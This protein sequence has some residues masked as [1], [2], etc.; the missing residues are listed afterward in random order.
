MQYISPLV[1]T[2]TARSN[3]CH[4]AIFGRR[5]AG[6][7]SLLNALAGQGVAIV[8]DV[9]GTTADTVWKNIELPG[10]GAAVIGDTAGFDDE[11]ALGALRVEAARKAVSKCDIAIMLLGD[12]CD[13]ALEREWHAEI[14]RQNVPLLLVAGKCDSKDNA[15]RAE[16]WSGVFGS[17]VIPF[18]AVTGEGRDALLD[19]LAKCYRQD[20]NLDDIT[21]TLVSAGDLVVLVMPQDESAPKGRLIQ[22]QV[23]T[24]RNLIDKHCIPLCCAPEELPR[25]LASLA[26]PPKLIITDSQLFAEVGKI[27]PAGTS[28]TSFSVLMA[29]HKGDIEA[30]MEGAKVLRMLPPSAKVLIAEAC[31]HVP[32]NEDIGRVKLPRLLRRKIGEELVIDVVSGNDF[33]ENLKE[34]SLIIHCGACMFNRR[35]VM[36][37]VRQAKAQ[38]VPITNYGIAIAALSGILERVAL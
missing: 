31:A 6:K 25:L 12:P 16:Y 26:V 8:S 35:T 17:S 27:A 33:P 21:Y 36:A 11:G 23:L 34:Y 4:I 20:D 24:L 19:A 5:N 3:R 29:R 22:P 2:E 30:F 28:L 9:A 7:S 10:I 15:V 14:M 18:S 38:G 13:A 1:M 32:K 37:R